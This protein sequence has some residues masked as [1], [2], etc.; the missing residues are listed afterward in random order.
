MAR[1]KEQGGLGLMGF[2]DRSDALQMRYMTAILDGRN[3]EWNLDGEKDVADQAADWA[4]QMGAETMDDFK[5][6]WVLIGEACPDIFAAVEEC[7]KKLGAIKMDDVS[8][9]E[10]GR[11]VGAVMAGEARVRNVEAGAEVL[12]WLSEAQISD[13][14]LQQIVGWVWQPGVLVGERWE[15]PNRIWL[16]MLYSRGPSVEG[17]NRHWRVEQNGEIWRS[18]W[19]L[20]WAGA[21]LMK[22]QNVDMEITAAGSSDV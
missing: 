22:H 12:R 8:Q 20:L 7:A 17:L 19:R 2:K 5:K 16:R 18:R 13:R 10:W 6:W 11:D 4:M 9:A 21:A 3:I 14:P 15:L 1:P